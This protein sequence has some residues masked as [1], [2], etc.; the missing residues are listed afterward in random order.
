LAGQPHDR[1]SD[2]GV[3]EI[4]GVRAAAREAAAFRPRKRDRAARRTGLPQ[5]GNRRE[6]IHLR[7]NGEEP[8][9]QHL[10]QAWRFRPPRTRALRDPPSLDRPYLIASPAWHPELL[11]RRGFRG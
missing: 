7:T 2:E 10:R 3:C 1:G 5:Q 4:L 6:A 8:P 11:A 9:A